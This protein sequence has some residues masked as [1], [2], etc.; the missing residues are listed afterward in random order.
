MADAGDRLHAI[1]LVWLEMQGDGPPIAI[2][3]VALAEGA[4]PTDDEVLGMVA[5]RL[6][7]MP[8][9]HQNLTEP[10]VGLRRPEWVEAQDVDL[11][12]HLHRIDASASGGHVGLDAAVSHI[13][14]QPLP[15]GEPLW[16]LWVVDGLEDRWALVWRVHHTIADGLGAMLML[17]HGFDCESDGGLTLADAILTAQSAPAQTVVQ[18]ATS[19]PKPVALAS[20]VG[21]RL[22]H[23]LDALRGAVPHV[24]P[25]VTAVV[26]HPPGPLTGVVGPGRVWV[27]VD[28]PLPEVKA[29][30]RALGATVND[31]VLACVAGGFR[32][33]LIHRGEPVDGRLVRNLVPVSTRPPGDDRAQNR[34][35]ALLGHLPVGI[36][37]PLDRL[38]A[39]RAGVAHGREVGT[40][41]MASALLGLVDRAVPAAVQDVAVAAVGRTAPAWF[42]DTLTTNVPGPQFPVYVCRRRVLAMYPL[43]PVAGHTCITTGIFSYDGTLNIGVT[44]DADQAGDVDVL[45]RG[46]RN[47]SVELAQLAALSGRD[48]AG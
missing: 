23:V 45:G 1:D 32:D 38:T 6:D 2:G 9:L 10:G 11:A 33:L 35:T 14:E 3:T 31:I 39:V 48:A 37:D 15:A 17:G 18:P 44:G 21:H 24:I 22:G 29:T 41:A 20:E 26:P 4:A 30:G 5:G 47:A 19:A 25:A 28:I 13:M 42:M 34:I 16:D 27:S 12:A 40:P 43:I 8:R 7:R 36:A 46:I